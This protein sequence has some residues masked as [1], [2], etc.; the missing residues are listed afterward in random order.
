MTGPWFDAEDPQFARFYRDVLL[1]TYH[2]GASKAFLESPA[3]EHDVREHTSVRYKRFANHLVPWVEFV[4][5][6]EGTTAIE[7]G[8]GTGSATLAFAPRV[9]HIHCYDI[10]SRSIEAAQNCLDYFSVRNVSFENELFDPQCRFVTAGLQADV[11]LLIAV[12]EH[13]TFPELETTLRLAWDTLKPGGILVVAETPNRLSL[14]DYHT[15]FLP[16]FHWLSPELKLL[17]LNCSPRQQL[18]DEMSDLRTKEPNAAALSLVRWGGG[19]SFHEFEIVLGKDF[20]NYI[21]AT[22][23]EDIILPIVPRFYDDDVLL[24]IFRK[25]DL[26]VSPAF[27]RWYLYFVAK[28]SPSTL[29]L[30][31][32]IQ[33]ARDKDV[34]KLKQ[35]IKKL[36]KEINVLRNSTSWKMTKP[37]RALASKLLSRRSFD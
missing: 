28:K 6:L 27:A 14:T 9:Q 4:C 7:V 25:L 31:A 1:R 18:V 8:S 20:H 16:F 21:I 37:F 32:S 5:H 3:Y 30:P 36:E 29:A 19:I 34:G 22:G 24:R 12:L 2:A 15:S 10:A 35:R 13:M 11:V 26:K 23:H 33:W 17:Y